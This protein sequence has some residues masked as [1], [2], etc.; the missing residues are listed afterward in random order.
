MTE[1][2]LKLKSETQKDD[3]GK[4]TETLYLTQEK[5]KL[6]ESNRD[7]ERRL[8]VVNQ[9]CQ[10]YELL[11]MEKANGMEAAFKELA[12]FKSESSGSESKLLMLEE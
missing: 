3:L 7:L 4:V 6:S 12:I 9:R 2:L 10:E 1:E 11:L 8:D 5:A